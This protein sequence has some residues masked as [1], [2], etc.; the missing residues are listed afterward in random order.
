MCSYSRISYQ[1]Q[2]F[3]LNPAGRAMSGLLYVSSRY[4]LLGYPNLYVELDKRAKVKPKS[5]NL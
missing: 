4:L 1:L 2:H 3:Q 5:E